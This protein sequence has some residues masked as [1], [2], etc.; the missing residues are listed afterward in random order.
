MP[1]L[2]PSRVPTLSPTLF[3]TETRTFVPSSEPSMTPQ[4][5]SSYEVDPVT[6][7]I[8]WCGPSHSC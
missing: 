7:I 1:T 3:P 8:R 6:G 2:F 5:M 4:F